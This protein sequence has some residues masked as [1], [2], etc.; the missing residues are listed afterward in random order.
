MKRGSRLSLGRAAC[1]VAATSCDPGKAKAVIPAIA[2]VKIEEES[3]SRVIP[4]AAEK[5]EPKVA[6]DENC[7]DLRPLHDFT[8]N[9]DPRVLPTYEFAVHEL[10]TT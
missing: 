10:S 3:E 2:E 9:I 1:G 5:L 8:D 4:D 7:V 6:I